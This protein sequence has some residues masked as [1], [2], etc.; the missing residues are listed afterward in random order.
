[1]QV[2][3]APPASPAPAEPYLCSRD[4]GIVLGNHLQIHP[5]SLA[6]YAKSIFQPGNKK[7]QGQRNVWS[8]LSAQG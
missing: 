6:C 7:S 3:P 5:P 8:L 2:P 4:V 1:M